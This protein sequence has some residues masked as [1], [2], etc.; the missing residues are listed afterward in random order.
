[1]GRKNNGD[2]RKA[3]TPVNNE[4]PATPPNIGRFVLERPD[5]S[6]QRPHVNGRFDYDEMNGALCPNFQ[7]P[8]DPSPDHRPGSATELFQ[9]EL[10]STGH[11]GRTEKLQ[12]F[13]ALQA[14]QQKLC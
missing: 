3:N 1:V 14:S 9:V 7:R 5:E 11:S 6:R 2:R 10:A 8:L 4:H 12:K 13:P